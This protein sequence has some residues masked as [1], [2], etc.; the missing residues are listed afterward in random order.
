MALAAVTLVLAGFPLQSQAQTA[1][2]TLPVQPSGFQSTGIKAVITSISRAG[3]GLAINF[4]VQNGR[5]SSILIS[6]IVS[7]SGAGVSVLSS[8]GG[9]YNIMDVD[10]NIVGMSPCIGDRMDYA[11]SISACLKS[12]PTENMTLL[13]PNQTAPLGISYFLDGF[14]QE[15]GDNINFS[16]KFLVRSVPSQS[17]DMTTVL[18][19]DVSA[20]LSSVVTINFPLVPVKDPS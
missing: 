8:S 18:N 17:D 4:L 10:H 11:R 19:K 13:E 7:E 9:H 2:G 3:R 5:K 15:D 20:G 16:L 1:P 12:F 14:K 6:P